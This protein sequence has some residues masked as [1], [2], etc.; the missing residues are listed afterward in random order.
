M[1]EFVIAAIPAIGIAL[2]HFLWQGALI[3]A[4]AALALHGLRHARPQARYAVACLALLACVLAPIVTFVA[5][6]VLATPSSMPPIVAPRFGTALQARD[7]ARMAGFLAPA[8]AAA[9]STWIV[10]LWAAGSGVLFLRMALGLAWIRHLRLAPQPPLQAAWQARLDALALR[11]GLQRGVTLRVVDTLDSPVSAGW[12]RPV[13]LVPAALLAR[14]PTD[15]VE[16]LLAHE[17]AHIRRHDYLVNL[18][19]NVVEALLFYHPVT[20]WLS[21]RIR[22]ERELIADQLAADTLASPRTLAHALGALADA[23]P[24]PAA[25]RLVQAAH[26]GDLLPRIQRL[27]RPAPA[28]PA[29]GR[30]VLALLGLCAICTATWAWASLPA[31]DAASPSTSPAQRATFAFVPDAGSEIVFWGP[32]DD[33]TPADI[34]RHGLGDEVLWVRANGHDYAITDAVL[35]ERARAA[36]RPV[37]AA[38]AELAVLE[39]TLR[40]L[41]AR[42][43]GLATRRDALDVATDAGNPSGER[44]AN[45]GQY[46]RESTALAYDL[47]AATAPMAALERRMDELFRTEDAAGALA[48]REFRAVFADAQRSGVAHRTPLQG[49]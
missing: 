13:V 37:A 47:E 7:V 27:L 5:Q 44:Q 17:L 12:W 11:F 31:H 49:R 8:H 23:L 45:A 10:A 3:G 9:A 16:A 26:G 43:D 35:L 14:L 41:Q 29:G 48:E 30:I 15:L 2:L 6:A 39:A 34:E 40:D 46:E 18:L 42:A 20:W 21:R 32:D 33:M 36:W 28:A 25:L 1:A 38:S 19:Q 22:I 24:T 4:L